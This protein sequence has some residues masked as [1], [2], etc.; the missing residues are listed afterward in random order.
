M[1]LSGS[2]SINLGYNLTTKMVPH[3]FGNQIWFKNLISLTLSFAVVENIAHHLVENN[4]L[5]LSNAQNLTATVDCY[6]PNGEQCRP[7]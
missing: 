4:L 3:H 1:T 7:L 6:L 5:L 2:L